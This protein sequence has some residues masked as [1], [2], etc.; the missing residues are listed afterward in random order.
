MKT[1]VVCIA[2]DENQ[3]I[4]E[5][6]NYY[7][8]LG[9]DEIFMYE[10]DWIC[11]IDRPLLKKKKI[12]GNHMQMSAYNDFLKNYRNDYDWIAFFDVDE[13]LVLK[14]HNN[15]KDF[16]MENDNG[17]GIA[18]NWMFF[19][20]CGKRERGEYSNSLLKQFTKRQDPVDQHI[21]TIM[22]SKSGAMM[23]LPHNPNTHL[24]DTNGKMVSGPFNKGGPIDQVQLNHYHHKTYEDWLIRCKRGQADHTPTKVP[25]E[26]EQNM[27]VFCDVDD[28]TARDYMYG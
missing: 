8:K 10:N 15:I 11:P 16:L 7:E 18:V 3:Y 20:A 24:F 9:F 21:K 17:F 23:V 19:G 13:F 6:V 26:W 5:W 25:E 28:F 27:T 1:V 4:E 12:F 14:K 22:K 2:K